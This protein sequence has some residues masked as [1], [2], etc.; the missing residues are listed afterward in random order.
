MS[1]KERETIARSASRVLGRLP[2]T[3]LALVL[4]SI[5]LLETGQADERVET[6]G[7]VRAT[8]IDVW[9][10]TVTRG[11]LPLV[12]RLENTA[13]SGRTVRLQAQCGWREVNIVERAV[14]LD[15]GERIR[16]DLILPAF[17]AFLS[18]TSPNYTLTIESDGRDKT[19]HGLGATGAIDVRVKNVMTFARRLP[20]PGAPEAWAADISSAELLPEHHHWGGVSSSSPGG[21]ADVELVAATFDELPRRYEPYSSLHAVVLDTSDGLPSGEVLR[22][23]YTYARLGGMVCFFGR[24]AKSFAEEQEEVKPWM[25]QRFVR[26]EGEVQ[27]F[28]MGF[29]TLVIGESDEF[30]SPMQ[31]GELQAQLSAHKPFVPSQSSRTVQSLFVPGIGDI[32]YRIF[33]VL[34]IGF[35]LLIGPVNFIF[36]KR[37]GRPALLLL[38]IPAIALVTSVLLLGY[39]IFYQGIDTKSSSVSIALLDQRS[40][41]V[42]VIED[43]RCFVGL[44]RGPGLLPGAGTSC[45]PVSVSNESPRFLVDESEDTVLSGTYLPAREPVHQMLLAERSSR[46]RLDVDPGNGAVTVRNGL[47][48][49]IEELLVRESDGSWYVTLDRVDAGDEVV[50]DPLTSNDELDKLLESWRDEL[51]K[52]T[53]MEN[54]GVPRGAYM[55]RLAEPVFPDSCGVDLNELDGRHGVLGLLDREELK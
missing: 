19:I 43:R 31:V 49:A 23:L 33:V 38:T 41:R 2:R 35:A 36:V 16:L 32:P 22:P 37:S 29:G 11:Y 27:V 1:S 3:L 7:G 24:D 21:R 28:A 55:A 26:S 42:D 51:G 54:E 52:G 13:N 44:S 48:V 17:G 15:A 53:T 47:G 4:L 9:P 20:A 45:Y 18:G 39:G 46:L 25:E 14:R 50:L 40:D 12:V 6:V 30:L 34:L 8:V 5:G 10:D